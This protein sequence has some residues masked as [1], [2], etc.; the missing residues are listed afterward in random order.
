MRLNEDSYRIIVRQWDEIEEAID[1]LSIDNSVLDGHY[2]DEDCNG[3]VMYE[4]G[5]VVY[6]VHKEADGHYTLL[7]DIQ[8]IVT[9]PK[10]GCV[11]EY[12]G[13]ETLSVYEMRETLL[14]NHFKINQ[15]G[16]T[17]TNRDWAE[18]ARNPYGAGTDAQP[19]R[20]T[21]GIYA[22]EYLPH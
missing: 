19:S 11:E 2:L 21:H 7:D 17:D 12:V 8:L 3:D 14:E 4:F 16:R 18:T 13:V 6:F 22:A 20:G 10:G 5:D 1:L 15:Y 9:I